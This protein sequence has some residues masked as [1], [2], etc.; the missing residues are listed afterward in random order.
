MYLDFLSNKMTVAIKI[1]VPYRL[2]EQQVHIDG[3][4]KERRERC[5]SQL[6]V[7]LTERQRVNAEVN[8]Q[9]GEDGFVVDADG[10]A[11]VV[12]VWRVGQMMHS[13]HTINEN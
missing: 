1:I 8:G 6:H 11:L 2:V 5:K 9:I 12:L 10:G 4:H 3:E 7:L 13:T